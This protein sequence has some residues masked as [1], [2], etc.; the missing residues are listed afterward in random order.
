MTYIDLTYIDLCVQTVLVEQDRKI[1]RMVEWARENTDCGV[2][3]VY[4]QFGQLRWLYADPA[5]PHGELH[6]RRVRHTEPAAGQ[7]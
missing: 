6:E 2:T 7:P 3:V 4:D 1:A 5:V